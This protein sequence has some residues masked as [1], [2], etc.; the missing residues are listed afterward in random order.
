MKNLKSLIAAFL[1]IPTLMLMSC[2]DENSSELDGTG[3]ARIE[4][5]DAAVDAQNISGVFL[6]VDEAQVIANGQV[7]NSITFD[8]PREFNLMDFQNGETYLLGEL[9]LEA[10]VYDEIRLMLTSTNEAFVQFTDGSTEAVNVPSGSSSGYKINGDFEI[11]ANGLTEVVLDVDLRK[12]LVKR[13]NGEFNLRPTA[14]LIT[15]SSTGM[16]QG[17]LDEDD[18]ENADRVVVFAYLEG[19]FQDS[20]MEEPTEG[21]AR[22][23][24]SVNSAIADANGNFTL[25]FMPEGDYELVVATFNENQSQNRFEFETA[26]S[27]NVMLNG[28]L[29]TTVDVQARIIT[30][31]L[32]NLF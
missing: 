1:I 16:I 26:T 6:S 20:E 23:E 2:D 27:V 11:L 28:S 4:A 19:T 31:I 32:I 17:E 12:A 7:Q 10:G 13:G 24:N 5:T 15:K 9:D 3:T 8:S 18:M 14:R 29:S 21:N 22:F 25:A 30:D